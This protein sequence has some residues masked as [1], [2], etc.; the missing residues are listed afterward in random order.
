M[1]EEKVWEGGRESLGR[2][3]KKSR[4][5]EEK[6]REGGRERMGRGKRKSGK[7]EEKG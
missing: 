5:G 7:G 2:G 6:V 3:K 4:K 1:E